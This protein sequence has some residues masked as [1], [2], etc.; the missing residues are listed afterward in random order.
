MDKGTVAL[1]VDS[2]LRKEKQADGIPVARSQGGRGRWCPYQT[3][4]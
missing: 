1:L 4:S 2:I 3:H